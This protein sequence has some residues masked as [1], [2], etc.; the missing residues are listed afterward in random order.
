[1]DN[2]SSD[3]F[4]KNDDKHYTPES[5]FEVA[6]DVVVADT[7]SVTE[8]NV[9]QS[10]NMRAEPATPPLTSSTLPASSSK[11]RSLFKTRVV[12]AMDSVDF[13]QCDLEVGISTLKVPSPEKYT[14]LRKKIR[15]SNSEW[16]EKFLECDGLEAL[17]DAIGTISQRR[18]TQLADAMMLMKCVSCIK[19][20]MNTKIGFDHLIANKEAPTKLVKG[21]RMKFIEKKH[22]CL[23]TMVKLAE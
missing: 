20:V 22:L 1:M 14:N 17:L 8:A 16:L 3:K 13:D 11:K 4:K 21:T 23:L 10:E 5:S 12:A 7:K 6:D 19:E 15:T 9:D 2:E 18:V